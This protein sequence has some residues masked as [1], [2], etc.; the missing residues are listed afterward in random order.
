VVQGQLVAAALLLPLQMGLLKLQQEEGWGVLAQQLPQQE[1]GWVLQLR[2]D[3]LKQ[4]EEGWVVLQ[5]L[6]QM[7]LL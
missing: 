1:E 5:L 7:G 6:Q 3:L 2:M 4:Q